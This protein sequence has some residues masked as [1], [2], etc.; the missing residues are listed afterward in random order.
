MS[1]QN[2]LLI[3]C[4]EAIPVAREAGPDL[5]D[6]LRAAM[7]KTYRHWMAT[8][9]DDQFQAAIAACLEVAEEEDKERIMVAVRMLGA[10]GAAASGVP[11][12]F[13]SMDVEGIPEPAP[14]VR[15][16]DEVKAAHT[17]G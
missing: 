15:I 6:R 12:D 5:E 2:A 3:A 16:W 8:D 9:E 7:Q 4:T 13:A 17:H 1:N 14:L 10:L 11:V